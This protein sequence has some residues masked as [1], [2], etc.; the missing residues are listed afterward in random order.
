[1]PMVS[2]TPIISIITVV[3]NGAPVIEQAMQSVLS[4]KNQDIEYLVI[5]GGSTDGTCA[6][7]ERYQQ[8]LDFWSSEPDQ[9]IFDAMNKGIQHA[10][11]LFI[12]ML[13][14]D[15]WYEPGFL[16]QVLTTINDFKDKCM[17]SYPVI[18]CDYYIWDASFSPPLKQTAFSTMNYWK[19]MTVSHQTMFVP[20]EVYQQYG[21][22][23]LTYRF[24]ADYE[25]FLRMIKHRV[26]FFKLSVCGVN[27]R[28]GGASD[29]HMRVSIDEV[30]GIVR[31][32]FGVFSK[33]YCLFLL[34]NRLPSLL[35][36]IRRG[37]AK[38]LGDRF[39]TQ[40]RRWWRRL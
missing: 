39:T 38:I 19:G 9:G 18:Y 17:T 16:Q 27:F 31:R 12:V 36:P 11:G 28:K 30:S 8:Q 24:A 25:F 5:D 32:Y 7:I 37:L 22:Y 20:R 21:V 23:E 29:T 40:L 3:Y 26:A 13:N 35:N 33:E 15:D 4:Q 6:I 34:G 10:R 2:Q 14:A 1:M